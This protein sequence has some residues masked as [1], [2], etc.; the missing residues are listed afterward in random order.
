MKEVIKKTKQEIELETKYSPVKVNS[1]HYYFWVCDKCN[2][3][4]FDNDIILESNSGNICPI[5]KFRFIFWGDK[6]CGNSITGGDEECFNKYYK[7]APE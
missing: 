6:V 1:T 3:A 7:L 5:E 4:F 2:L